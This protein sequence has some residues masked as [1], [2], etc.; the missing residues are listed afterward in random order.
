[1]KR[2]RKD[3]QGFS[4]VE[5]IVVVLI[6]AIIAVALAP[7]VLKW[8]NNARISTDLN[9]MDSIKTAAQTAL[10]NEDAYAEIR[11]GGLTIIVN[12]KGATISGNFT[13]FEKKFKE[14]S[15]ATI[16]DHKT[17]DFKTKNGNAVICVT[18]DENAKVVGQYGTGGSASASTISTYISAVND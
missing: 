9:T 18:I 12:N 4:L 1:M 14:Y 13:S 2:L 16:N 5:L 11:K 6:M 3:N 8:V 7:Q 15:G 10:T 17:T